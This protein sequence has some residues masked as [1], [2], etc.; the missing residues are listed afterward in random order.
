M[1][2]SFVI[3]SYNTK[4]LLN[5]TLTT[6]IDS[7]EE[8]MKYEIF[9][10]D[11]RSSDGT[12]ELL[13][14]DFPQV[15]LIINQNNEGYTRAMNMGLK[16]AHGEYLV[17]LNPD[18]EV[19][20][21]TF[22]QLFQWMEKNQQV[23]IGTPKVLNRDGSL[24]RQCRRS[25]ARPWDVFTYFLG[26]DRLFP[27]N[28]F[29]GRYL[30]PYLPEDDIAWVEAV[31]GSCMFVRKKVFEQIGF[32]D[33]RF[34]AYQEDADFCFRANQAGWVVAYLP[35][36]RI[37]HYGGMGGS[38]NQPFRAI[39]AWHRSYYLYY[40]KNIAKEYFFLIN[41]FMY[42]AMVIKLILALIH[43]LF[44][45]EKIVGTKKPGV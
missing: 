36:A 26:L 5:Q 24:Q 39:L 43:A 20:P 9:V 21:N 37:F 8:P 42:F 38:R 19:L 30:M 16:L 14:N 4:E 41:W 33:E 7:F 44:S 17:Q 40:K 45:R 3:V 25:F 10:I 13:Q 6:L 18:V 31:S 11:N 2:I 35:F 1:D 27:K 28:K 12:I 23:G 29:F 32:L 15:N 34:F 22:N